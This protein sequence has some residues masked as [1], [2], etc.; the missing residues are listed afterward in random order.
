M[1]VISF[2]LKEGVAPALRAVL[3]TSCASLLYLTVSALGLIAVLTASA[4]AFALVRYVG[5]AYLIYLGLRML[6]NAWRHKSA[7]GGEVELRS[8]PFLQGLTTHLSNPKAI[9]YWTALLP[10]FIEPS[11][12]VTRQIMIL[13]GIAILADLLV[14]ASYAVLAAWARGWLRKSRPVSWIDLVAG[15]FLISAGS[16]L[17]FAGHASA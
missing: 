8:R 1:M 11:A 6:R 12:S 2:S 4:Q 7:P 9:V 5:A 17:A 13:G 10:Q 14:L 15:S 3:G 16:L